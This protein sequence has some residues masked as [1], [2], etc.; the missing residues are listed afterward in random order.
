M[1]DPNDP[2]QQQQ[3]QPPQQQQ[4][5]FS[6]LGSDL[7]SVLSS[8]TVK[9]ALPALIGAAGGALTG[10]KGHPKEQLGRA[11][12]GGLQGWQVGQQN[13][14]RQ[15]QAQMMQLY[16]GT[17]MKHMAVTDQ[18]NEGKLDAQKVEKQNVATYDAQPPAIKQQFP[19]YKIWTQAMAH[20]SITGADVPSKQQEVAK[21][22]TSGAGSAYLASRGIRGPGDIPTSASALNDVLKGYKYEPP[23]VVAEHNASIAASNARVGEAAASIAH[24]RVSTVVEDARLHGT[25]PAPPEDADTKD[26]RK[27]QIDYLHATAPAR[28]EATEDKNTQANDKAVTGVRTAYDKDHPALGTDA[29]RNKAVLQG[30]YDPL[31]SKPLPGGAMKPTGKP[32]RLANGSILPNGLHKDANGNVAY[33]LDGMIYT[34]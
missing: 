6:N 26:L 16:R 30:G 9:E 29:G 10:E 31:T 34:H 27:A 24:N 19:T 33:V 23:D 18:L 28:V 13:Q 22:L 25:L 12:E 4:G 1:P 3:S 20:L 32:A 15:Q 2:N 21:L 14:L 5:F 11:L 17:M 8:P 7:A